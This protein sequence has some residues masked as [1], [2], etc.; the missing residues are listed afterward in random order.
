M[1]FGDVEPFIDDNQDIAPKI[2]GRLRGITASQDT[3]CR[4]KLELAAVIDVGKPFVT[5]TYDLE[6]DSVLSQS[7]Y[8]RVQAVRK[9]ASPACVLSH[10]M[11]LRQLKI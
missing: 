10:L 11:L 9:C 1:S 8:E 6:G 2:V 7:V 3:K 4:L 5:A